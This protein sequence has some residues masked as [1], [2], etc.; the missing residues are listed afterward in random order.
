MAVIASPD[1]LEVEGPVVFLAGPIS[2]GPDAWQERA[3]ALLTP[4]VHVANPRRDPAT[5]AT[6]WNR[7]EDMEAS[8]EF[9]ETAYNAQ[10]D[11]ET[12]Y[13]GLAGASG[14]ILFW[15]ARERAHNCAR[16]H[17]QTTRFE[18]AEWKLRHARDGARLV[19]GI[20][21]GFTGARY[22]RRRFAQ[23]CPDITVHDTLEATCA[24]AL[25][26]AVPGRSK[27]SDERPR[28]DFRVP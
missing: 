28:P 20:E 10:M 22:I 17:A 25:A 14:A 7:R 27:A 11:W 6:L 12:R 24:A 1:I 9:P 3:I 2:W 16:P 5:S 21:D 26:L 13:L 18:L 15:L 23:D 19:I 8:G 4:H